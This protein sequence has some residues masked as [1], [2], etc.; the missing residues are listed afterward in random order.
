MTADPRY[1]DLRT[2]TAAQLAEEHRLIVDAIDNRPL[3][4]S[5]EAARQNLINWL[6]W[7]DP[8]GCYTDADCDLEGLP[9]LTL[10]S[11][12]LLYCDQHSEVAQ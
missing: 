10:I 12:A 1:L 8:N 9:R 11:A 7:N 2:A 6:V 5:Q 4:P 3:T